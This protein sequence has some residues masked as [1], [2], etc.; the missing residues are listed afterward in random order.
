MRVAVVEDDVQ[1]QQRL[2]AHLQ[3]YAQARGL[4]LEPLVFAD[5]EEIVRYGTAGLDLILMDIQMEKL[6]GM[7]AAQQLR[8]TDRAIPLI[9][10]TSMVNYAVQGYR[11][12]AL[13][14][15][16][17]P[18]EYSLLESALDRAQ[19]RLAQSE[20]K[21]IHV[22]V[23]KERYR[24]DVRKLLYA[25]SQNHKLL[26]QTTEQQVMCTGTLHALTKELWPHGF[27]CCHAAFLIN[28]DRVEKLDGSDVLVG[29]CR[30]PVSKHRRKQLL[31]QL[32]ARWGDAL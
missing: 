5:G 19:A 31:E 2:C 25:E 8:Q 22:R 32:A 29:G 26:L 27:F 30:V 6:D 3:R 4:V 18:V 14:F 21:Y 15:L 13:D 24:L 7:A 11:V 17:K 28:L 23:G 16:V 12:E 9:F 20:P 1:E 10:V